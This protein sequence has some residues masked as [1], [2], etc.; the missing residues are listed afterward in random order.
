MSLSG[1]IANAISGLTATSRGT[2]IVASNIANAHTDGYGRRELDLSS[3]VHGYG[4]GVTIDGVYRVINASLL[5]DGRLA[6]AGFSASDTIAEFHTVMEK[7]VGIPTEP[8]SLAGLL[9]AFDSAIISAAARPDSDSRLTAVLES[10]SG[11][12]NKLNNVAKDIQGARTDA[13][14]AISN[15]VLRLNAALEQVASLNKQIAGRTAQG[16]D[17][18]SLIDSRQAAIDSISGIVPLKQV[19]RENGQIALFTTG[20][21]TLLDGS[22]PARIEFGAAGPIGPEMSLA[23][24]TLG[25]LSF[26]G[27]ELTSFQQAAMFSGGSLGASF[28]IR[29]EIAP[30]YQEQMDA[31][32]RDLYDRTSDPTIDATIPSGGAGLFTDDQG[33]LL[34]ANEPGFAGRIVVNRLVDPA[35]GG[36]LWRIRAGINAA[37]PGDSGE[38]ALLNGLSEALSASRSPASG[39]LSSSQKTLYSLSS[40]ISSYAA[41]NRIR[42]EAIALQDRS[43]AES[44]RTALLGDGVDSDKEMESLL[45][46]ERAYSANA[47]V[48]QS[49]NDM[50]DT[51]LRLT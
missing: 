10:A 48:F 31:F 15:D 23:A 16:K 35:S 41:S 46:L 37:D 18:S 42:T 7:T 13:E 47:K 38:S 14:K 26:N 1:A 8:S 43:R 2:E 5:A 11:L 28:S 30:K 34:A 40:D 6:Q 36:D 33:Q 32:A 39:N 49:A 12:A 17:A 9:A 45:A 22:E 21:A 27:R 29:D 19:P 20:G 50:L 4:G 51:V 44:L 24:G 3:R 25:N